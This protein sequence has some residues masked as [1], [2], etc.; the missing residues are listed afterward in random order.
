MGDRERWETGRVEYKR[1]RTWE[2]KRGKGEGKTD[3]QTDRWT[4]RQRQKQKVVE[5]K[6]EEEREWDGERRRDIRGETNKY[7]QNME[8]GEIERWTDV[9]RNGDRKTDLEE[10]RNK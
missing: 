5:T 1:K 10:D 7:Q 6:G 2:R 8:T 9:D 3:R 4:D